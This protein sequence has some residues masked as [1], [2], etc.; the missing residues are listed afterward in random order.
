MRR[1]GSLALLSVAAAGVAASAGGAALAAGGSPALSRWGALAPKVAAAEQPAEPA[2]PDTAGS[3]VI[4][5]LERAGQHATLVRVG[6]AQGLRA[7]DYSVFRDPLDPW[8]TT[9][10]TGAGK[11][12][13]VSVTCLF[14]YGE[15]L[16]R[17]NAFLTGRGRITFDGAAPPNNSPFTLAVTGGTGEFQTARGQIHVAPIGN[18]NTARIDISLAP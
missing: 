2:T 16:C 1:R 10:A 18:G 3:T 6:H 5:L 15:A 9:G 8:G 7:G 17:G 12:G 13:F 4:S 11:A 14:G